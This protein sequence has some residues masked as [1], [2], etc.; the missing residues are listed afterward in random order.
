MAL[1]WSGINIDEFRRDYRYLF[2]VLKVRMG[3]ES[4]RS[5]RKS[6]TKSKEEPSQLYP[7]HKSVEEMLN[8]GTPSRTR[9]GG[10]VTPD[11]ASLGKMS[12]ML[13]K[14]VKDDPHQQALLVSLLLTM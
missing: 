4:I 6:P 8:R 7:T 12:N 2:R 13:D 11:D 10:S 3:N 1:K 14:S 5:S 9:G